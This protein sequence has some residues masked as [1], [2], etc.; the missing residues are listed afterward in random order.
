MCGCDELNRGARLANPLWVAQLV[1]G[2]THITQE[3]RMKTAIGLF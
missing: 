2:I 3:A 1:Q